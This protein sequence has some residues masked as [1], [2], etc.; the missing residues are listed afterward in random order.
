MNK[1]KFRKSLSRF[2]KCHILCAR[3]AFIEN[4]TDTAL[5][6]SFNDLVKRITDES[7]AIETSVVEQRSNSSVI[8]TPQMVTSTA[9]SVEIPSSSSIIERRS[10]DDQTRQTL[11]PTSSQPIIRTTTITNGTE[12]SKNYYSQILI[13]IL[14]LLLIVNIY[15]CSKLNQIDRMTDRLLQ[16]YPPWLNDHS[17]ESDQN[18]WSLLLQRQEEYY[19][20]QLSGLQSVLTSTHHALRNVTETLN[21]LSKLNNGSS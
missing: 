1:W 2:I 14:F 10:E 13:I 17:L 12:A 19:Q 20:R 5:K 8:S 15:L 18:Q 3:S 4:S 9:S 16:S 7:R 6:E 11:P 21:R